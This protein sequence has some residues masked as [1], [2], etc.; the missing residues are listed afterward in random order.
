MV[1]AKCHKLE[2]FGE[3]VGAD[4]NAIKDRGTA[5]VMLNILDPNREV[6]PQFMNY[7]VVLDTG[8]TLT[9]MIA[10]E[11]ANGLTIRKADGTSESLLRV[12][13]DE[14]KSA[15]ISYMPEGLEQQLDKQAMADLLA[16]LN[17][18]K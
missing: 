5:A 10:A 18:I 7:V 15:G 14:I 13:I 12:N 11:S 6:K 2:G 8:R 17:S 9:G 3:S 16:Y 1:C 4:L